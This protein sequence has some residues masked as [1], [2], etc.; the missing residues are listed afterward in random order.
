MSYIINNSRGMLVAVVPA[1]TVNTTSTSLSLVGQGV[2]NYGTDE[3]ENYIYLLENFAAPTSPNSPMLGQLW[4]DS[5][6]D[7]MKVWNS[8]NVWAGM[9][10]VA[11]V[12]AQKVSPAFTGVPTAPTPD[13]GT[14]NTQ[15]ATTSFVASTVLAS[16]GNISALLG[17]IAS[18]NANAVAITGGTISNVVITGGSISGL[19]PISIAD[20]GTG[21]TDIANA[22][23]NLGLGSMSLQA[24]S[25][26]SITGGTITGIASLGTS[27]ANIT[28]D[29]ITGI[30]PLAIEDGGTGA[31]DAAT[32]RTNLGV[33]AATTRIIVGSGLT[34][35]GIINSNVNIGIAT[36]SNGFGTRYVSTSAPAPGAGANGDVWY[37]V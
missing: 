1:G 6:T 25:N 2:T 11:Y 32:A 14:S 17:T 37:Q 29:T 12:D 3:I 28:G 24:S 15:I 26:V 13:V 22:R 31:S 33:A 18:Q 5:S 7:T 27:S 35:G 19:A 30:T 23:I 10:S 20:G 21:A 4:Y 9:A 34:G 8:S 36:T 16:A